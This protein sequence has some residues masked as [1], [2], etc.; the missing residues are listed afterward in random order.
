MSLT[1]TQDYFIK[2]LFYNLDD[3]KNN[4]IEFRKIPEKNEDKQNEGKKEKYTSR[5][6]RT[7]T[8]TDRFRKSKIKIWM[9]I[10]YLYV[11][12]LV[13][14][15]NDMILFIV[16]HKIGTDLIIVSSYFIY[17]LLLHIT[18]TKYNRFS[19]H[20]W[21]LIVNYRHNF[22]CYTIIRSI[23]DIVD[24]SVYIVLINFTFS[25]L[26]FFNCF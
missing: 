18:C 21:I 19:W 14:S 24:S 8:T 4:F 23:N 1:I 11:R 3:Y 7:K 13:V 25:L 16:I 2:E 12:E 20:A 6:V 17:Y 10:Y 9:V 15:N 5:R 22:I 26:S